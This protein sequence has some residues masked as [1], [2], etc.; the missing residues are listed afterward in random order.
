MQYL[1]TKY[2]EVPEKY[3]NLKQVLLEDYNDYYV[4]LQ[5]GKVWSKVSKRFVK[6]FSNDRNHEI[7]AL[8]TKNG[9]KNTTVNYLMNKYFSFKQIFNNV[10]YKPML[11]FENKYL[12]L[13]DGRIYSLTH[14]KFIKPSYT[15]SGWAV[16][17]LVD[18]YGRRF[19]AYPD[20]I[21]YQAF[22]GPI[23]E[24]YRLVF[25][26]KNKTNCSIKNLDIE[27]KFIKQKGILS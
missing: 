2:F 4:L 5:N 22:N 6:T 20:R 11:G 1:K 25:K 27:Q 8:S 3:K 17:S 18:D 16:T 13:A 9:V 26:D 10:Q 23:K 21:V 7:I 14:Y 12:A 24:N 15:K 19:T